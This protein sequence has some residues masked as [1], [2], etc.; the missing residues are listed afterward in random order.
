MPV[1]LKDGPDIMRSTVGSKRK[2]RPEI[3]HSVRF[4]VRAVP[5]ME[6]LPVIPAGMFHR[7][8]SR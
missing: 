1:M 3:I 5:G 2:R 6:K 8:V 4:A 7:S